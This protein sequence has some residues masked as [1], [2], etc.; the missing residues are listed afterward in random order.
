MS[1]SS[2]AYLKRTLESKAS[3]CTMSKVE[4]AMIARSAIIWVVN[5]P[6]EISAIDY[7]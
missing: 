3:T 7:I 1:A 6:T 4:L 2:K 5:W